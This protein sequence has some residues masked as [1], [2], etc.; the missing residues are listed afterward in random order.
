MSSFEKLFVKLKLVLKLR[1]TYLTKKKTKL[2]K[3]FSMTYILFEI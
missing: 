3:N 2:L 1:L